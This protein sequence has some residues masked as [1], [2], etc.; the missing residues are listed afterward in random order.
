VDERVVWVSGHGG[1]FTRTLDGG[2]TWKAGVV[3]GA[4]TLQFRDVH[5]VDA[6]TAYLL[7]AGP[8]EL[9]R[10]YKTTD[11]GSSWALQFT[12][13][14]PRGFYDCIDFWSPQRGM[15]FSDAVDGRLLVI[16]TRDGGETWTPILRNRLPGALPGEGGFAASG[17]CLVTRDEGNAWIVTGAGGEARVFQTRDGGESWVVVSTPIVSGTATSGAMTIAFYDE[18]HGIVAGGELRD[19]ESRNDNVAVT[20]DG[21]RTWTLVGRP[22]ITGATYCI[23]YV[24]GRGPSTVVAV[25]PKGMDYSTDNGVRWTN[26]SRENYWSVGFASGRTGWAV[27]PGGRI[28]RIDFP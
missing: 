3:A 17:T 8:G 28:T 7:S 1:T 24:P 12:N 15:A 19:A 5:G 16:R 9:S 4:D 21:G 6:S 22:V 23:A 11:G 10:I 2:G 13:R 26:V 14:E 25:G 18:R 20:A 27:G